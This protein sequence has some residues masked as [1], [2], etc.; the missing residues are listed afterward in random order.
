M[1]AAA[2]AEV[3]K[4]RAEIEDQFA[5]TEQR[6]AA[7]EGRLE[8]LQRAARASKSAM[9]HAEVAS[10]SELGQIFIQL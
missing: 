10:N 9:E 7:A 5:A 1:G 3:E 8:E 4:L 6:A 2:R